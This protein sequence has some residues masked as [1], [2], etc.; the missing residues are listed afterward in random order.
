MCLFHTE[1]FNAED[2]A[3]GSTLRLEQQGLKCAVKPLRLWWFILQ[4]SPAIKPHEW[5][6]SP[7]VWEV[8]FYVTLQ[9]S[10]GF[11]LI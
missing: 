11:P 3:G 4:A 6:L 1:C 10:R 2:E 8:Q 9:S 5:P 7:S